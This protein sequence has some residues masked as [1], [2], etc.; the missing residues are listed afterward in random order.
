M[1]IKSPRTN[2]ISS[3]TTGAAPHPLDNLIWDALTTR[4]AGFAIGEGAARRFPTDVAPFVAIEQPSVRAYEELAQLVAPESP[5]VL[6][7]ADRVEP[8]PGLL[9]VAFER[10]LTQ[11]IVHDIRPQTEPL[12]FIELEP[13]DVPEMIALVELTKPGPY[14][15]RT[16]Q[17]GRYIGIRRDGQLVAMA[18]ERLKP[19]GFTEVSAV[20]THPDWRGHGFASGLVT[21]M[22]LHIR[23]RG[24][25][26]I[27]HT[28]SAN[29]PAISVYLKLGFILRRELWVSAVE[30]APQ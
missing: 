8:P 16:I 10:P 27:L 15:P 1:S 29:T 24:D 6:F 7:T 23:E 12:D 18:G 9:T 4:Q 28:G 5:A 13:A 22:A 19:E 26:P 25:I 3:V 20:C 21:Q 11:M 17:L 2:G 30:R 14:K